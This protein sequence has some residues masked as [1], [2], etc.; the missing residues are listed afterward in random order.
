MQND[1]KF[2]VLIPVYYK[3]NPHFFKTAIMSIIEQTLKPDEIVLVEDK[4]LP[5]EL[6]NTVCRLVEEHQGL[7]KIVEMYKTEGNTNKKRYGNLG[8]VLQ[9]GVLDCT[10]D[11][12]A[13]MDTD[14]IAEPERFEKQIRYLKENPEVDVVGSWISE[15]EENPEEII[16]YRVLPENHEDIYKFAQ[17]R[18]P[19]NH[20]TVM[21]RKKSVLEAGNYS[22]FTNSEDYYL[23]GRML[24]AGYKFHNIPECLVK[25]RS[26]KNMLKSRSNV[27]YFLSSEYPLQLEFFKMGFTNLYQFLRNIF[28]KFLLRILPFKLMNLYYKKFLRKEVKDA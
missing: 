6:A 24:K 21:F 7:F 10:Y 25:A 14:D 11:I 17:F 22:T 28:L 4:E 9:T 12:I 5:N 23:W 19:M 18:C 1:F 13:R 26:G 15:F 16:S 27:A 3:E 2:S 20:Q 8:K